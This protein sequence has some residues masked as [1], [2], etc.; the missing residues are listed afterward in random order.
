[1]KKQLFTLLL[2]IFTSVGGFSQSIDEAKLDS[3]FD[4]LEKNNKFMGS[5]AVSK[6]GTL[7][8]SKSVGFADVEQGIK[9]SVQ[10]KYRIGSISKT[11][12]TALVFKAIEEGKLALNQSIDKYFPT[13]A[14]ANKITITHLLYHR[15][16]IPNFTNDKSY[17]DWN[18][19][20]KTEQEMVAFISKLGSDFEPDTKASYSNSNFVLL[21]YILEKTYKK[22]YSKLI[23]E[24]ITKPADLKDTYYGSKIDTKKNECKSYKY[25]DNWKIELETDMSI[26]LG[27]GGIVST[28]RDL[29]KFGDLLFNGKIISENSLKQMETIR[30]NFGMG[31]FHIPF[32]DKKGFGHTGGIDGFNSMFV[33]F[34]GDS[35]AFAYASNGTNYNGNDIAIAVLSAVYQKPFEIPEFKTFDMKTEDLDKYVGIYSSKQISLKITISKDNKVLIAQAT[36]QPSFPL[37]AT[38]KDK[39]KFD[40]AKIVMEFNP[41]EKTMILKQGGGEFLFTKDEKNQE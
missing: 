41:E 20:P 36:G 24:K 34:P 9:A 31:L 38:E 5:V 2:L 28:P 29:I 25:T 17:M 32:Y 35:I 15:S 18:T 26:P 13:V 30:D 10:S 6:N 40:M 16:G 27:A 12:T 39:F 37:E 22:Q 21:T 14:N 7:L 1:M 33:S 11:F 4:T 8:Y 3:Y 23:E 19:Q